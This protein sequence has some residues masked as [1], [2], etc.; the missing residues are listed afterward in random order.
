MQIYINMDQL[1]NNK[2]A[3]NDVCVPFPTITVKLELML[4]GLNIGYNGGKIVICCE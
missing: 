4:S 2:I 1:I 3:F